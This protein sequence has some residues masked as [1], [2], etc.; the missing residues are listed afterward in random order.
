MS[1][2]NTPYRV[3]VSGANGAVM[4]FRMFA[5]ADDAASFLEGVIVGYWWRPVTTQDLRTIGKTAPVPTPAHPCLST[6][7]EAWWY[8]NK[9]IDRPLHEMRVDDVAPLTQLW[10]SPRQQRGMGV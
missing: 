9:L 8:E 6:R 10:R 5:R 7:V 2:T 4:S 3:L 1:E